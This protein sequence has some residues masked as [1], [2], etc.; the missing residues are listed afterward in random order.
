LVAVIFCRRRWRRSYARREEA[1]VEAG[2]WVPALLPTSAAAG[3]SDVVVTM[4]P[5]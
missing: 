3:C 1:V 4:L 2:W 5:P